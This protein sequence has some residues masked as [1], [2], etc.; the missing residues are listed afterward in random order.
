MTL[1][2]STVPHLGELLLNLDANCKGIIG[3]IL[4][5]RKLKESCNVFSFSLTT[6]TLSDRGWDSWMASPTQ[7]T[8]MPACVH[9]KLL[10]LC[11]YLYY[12]MDDRLP[13]DYVH[14]IL[15]SRILKWVT[16]SFSR[17]SSQPR[18]WTHVS[19]LLHWKAS[20]L[21]LVTSEKPQWTWVWTNSGT[22]WDIVK[23]REARCAAVHR[24]TKSWTLQ[25]LNN[26]EPHKTF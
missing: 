21:P 18:D 22:Y 14:G 8:D 12:P 26:F 16:I 5:H 4:Y 7:W 11:P 25:G 17:G 6:S 3:C 2:T 19:C 23:D 9:A 15:Q 10:Q 1:R 13:W 24:V 20:S